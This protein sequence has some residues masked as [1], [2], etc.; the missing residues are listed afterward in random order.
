MLGKR[1]SL[2][3]VPG[4]SPRSVQRRLATPEPDPLLLSAWDF[5]YDCENCIFQADRHDFPDCYG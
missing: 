4:D 3:S 5:E 1:R 2:V